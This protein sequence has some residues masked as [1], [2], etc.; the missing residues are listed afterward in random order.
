MR[1][2]IVPSNKFIS[3]LRLTCKTRPAGTRIARVPGYHP[4]LDH[5]LGIL[6]GVELVSS[7]AGGKKSRV[8]VCMVGERKIVVVAPLIRSAIGAAGHRLERCRVV[9]GTIG[10]TVAVVV[11][12]SS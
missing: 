1:N 2:C 5:R 7:H 9:G 8:S 12:S 11:P 3:S 10:V 6:H 4:V